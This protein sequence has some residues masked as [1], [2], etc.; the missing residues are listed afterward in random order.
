[1]AVGQTSFSSV[2]EG[3]IDALSMLNLETLVLWFPIFICGVAAL[4]D[5]RAR[6][7]P[8]WLPIAMIFSVP[9][10]LYGISSESNWWVHVAGGFV[11]LLG[12]LVVGYGDRF[13][14][15]DIKLFAALGAWFG[16]HAVLPLA[17]WVAI[18]G[19]PF[20]ILA[21]IRKQNDFAYAPA[22]LV[23]VMVHTIAPRLLTQIAGL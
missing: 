14:G 1:M 13:G 7:I 6:E 19:I 10:K 16:L 8:I 12:G 4:F 9:L 15:G 22:I 17:L 18:A 3:L 2:F 23:G 20:A 11:A 5:L 21:G